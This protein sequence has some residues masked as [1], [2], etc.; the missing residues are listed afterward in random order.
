MDGHTRRRHGSRHR[1]W[2]CTFNAPPPSPENPHLSQH[3]RTNNNNCKTKLGPQK[4]DSLSKLTTSIS[5]PNSPQSSKSELSLVGRM[6]PRRI[7]SP[8]RVSPIDHTDSLEEDRHSSH[9]TSSA[10]AVDT[11]PRSRSQSFRAKI[12]S[13]DTHSSLDPSRVEGE[14]GGA[15]DVRLNLKRKNGGVMVLELSSS[16]LASNSEVFAGLIAGSAGKKMYRIEVPEVENVG[17]FKETIELMFEEDIAKRLVKIGVNRAID[18]LEVSAGIMFRRGVSSCLKYL[19]AVPWTEEEE[20]KLRSLFTRF[21]FDEATSRDMLA[22]LH[23][24]QSTDTL[25]NLAR[26]LV[27]SITTCSDANARNELKSLVKGLLCKSSVYEKEQPDINKEDFY[28]VCQSCMSVLH[29]LFEEASDAIP[30]E[31]M[32]KKEM[33][34]PLIARISKQVDNIN[35]LLEILL[36]RQ[37]AEEFVDL[38]VNQGNLLKLHERA[39]PMVRYELSRVSAILFIAMGTRKLHCCSEARSGLLQAWFGPMLLD[40]GWL[41]RCRKGL[42]MK[43]LEEAMGQTLLTL[44]L[45]QQYVLFMEWFRCFSRNGSECP[46]LSKA[47]QIWWRRSF[48][49]GSET[50]AVESSLHY[51]DQCFQ[52]FSTGTFKTCLPSQIQSLA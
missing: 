10:A 14:I 7:L 51:G 28:A 40:F 33:G 43:A 22:R 3:Y 5:V 23:S 2:C 8:G 24:Q 36:D 44:P 52:N 13:P 45:K 37:M 39:S 34:K 31:R 38:W 19:E 12:E 48:L 17:V 35:F 47:F 49:R 41:Q 50:H 18:I 29:N 20:E 16:V 9:A 26:H 15:Y 1:S 4:P 32:T 25:Q 42:D 11:L 30:H 27:S 6:D 46:N 21:K